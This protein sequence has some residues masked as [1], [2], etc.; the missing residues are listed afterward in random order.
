VME[1]MLKDAAVRQA[2]KGVVAVPFQRAAMAWAERSR[3]LVAEEL[4]S[5]VAAGGASW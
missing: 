2:D 4:A 3:R 1:A 5:E